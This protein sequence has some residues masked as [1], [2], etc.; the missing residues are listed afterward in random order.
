MGRC[1]HRNIKINGRVLN[2]REILLNYSSLVNSSLVALLKIGYLNSDNL[3]VYNVYQV[4]C[5]SS[6]VARIHRETQKS[7]EFTHFALLAQKHIRL[8]WPFPR[9]TRAAHAASAKSYVR[10]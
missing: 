3:S 7:E 9:F 5:P 6:S 2:T 10:N 4:A 8:L 1:V